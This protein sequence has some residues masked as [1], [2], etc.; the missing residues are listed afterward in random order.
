VYGY[1]TRQKLSFSLG[2]YT[3]VFQAD[4]YGIKACAVD[5][6]DRDN[7]N[8]NIYSL[9]GSQVAIKA[10]DNYQINSEL[11]WYCHQTLVKLA[12]H[13]RVQMILVPE[14]EGIEGNETTD[15]MAKLGDECPLIRP[16]P[17]CGI[18]A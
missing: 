8:R 18:S 11:V 17:Y 12:K 5:N 4:M 14:H 7:K 2:K 1:V 16:E 10:P 13:N 6:L 9:S 15:Q 3:T